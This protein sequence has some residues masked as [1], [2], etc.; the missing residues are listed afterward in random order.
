MRF[1]VS[2]QTIQRAL[3]QTSILFGQVIRGTG[4]G[5]RVFDYIKQTPVIPLVGGLK[6][7]NL[8]GD[9]EFAHVTFAY[10][11]RPEQV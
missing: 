2:A 3:S 4:A 8:S 9:I 7:S 1:L 10:P 11:G 6:P 5:T